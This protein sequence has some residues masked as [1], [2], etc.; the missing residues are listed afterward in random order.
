MI[1]K[2]NFTEETNTKLLSC[3]GI[4]NYVRV[5]KPVKIDSLRGIND[6]CHR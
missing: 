4:S 2:S 6:S 5:V 3:N 1:E